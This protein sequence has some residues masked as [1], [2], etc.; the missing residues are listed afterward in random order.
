[1]HYEEGAVDEQPVNDLHAK[2]EVSE[3]TADLDI[4]CQEGSIP[5]SMFEIQEG[6]TAGAS[7]L[8]TIL[9]DP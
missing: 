3:E 2:K 6:Q 9:F 8:G 5:V 7:G 4:T 1:M